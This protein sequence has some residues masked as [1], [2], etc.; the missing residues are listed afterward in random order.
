MVAALLSVEGI[1]I[2]VGGEWGSIIGS[3]EK[4]LIKKA[5]FS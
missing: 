2:L 3:Q 4:T 5:I 1:C